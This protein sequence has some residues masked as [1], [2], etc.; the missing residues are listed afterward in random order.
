[1]DA[2]TDAC[3]GRRHFGGERLRAA[4]KL[5]RVGLHTYQTI[6]SKKYDLQLLFRADNLIALEV[7][8]G[9]IEL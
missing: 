2:I 7:G 9:K 3:H 5:V 1:M 8:E 6:N 4:E